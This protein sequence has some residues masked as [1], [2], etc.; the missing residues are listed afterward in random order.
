MIQILVNE[1]HVADNLGSLARRTNVVIARAANVGMRKAA[2]SIQNETYRRNALRKKDIRDILK[3]DRASY[4]H[5]VA[6]LTYTD[7]FKNLSIWSEG[8]GRSVV[9]PFVPHVG[10]SLEPENYF[11][12]VKRRGG[13]KALRG[14]DPIPF[15][16][17]AKNSKNIS[18]F[19]RMG[20][21]RYPIR[22][23]AAP[24]IPQVIKED[25][26]EQKVRKVAFDATQKEL[27]RQVKLQ[28]E[29]GAI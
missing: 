13:D 8:H 15:V 26:V 5:P 29:H 17:I 24:A 27:M 7:G 18:L 23:V 1:L 10:Y 2:V 3:R 9:K 28:I 20:Q 22:G 11:A 16:Q 25:D 14:G 19:T 12:H 6:T 21:S 4:T